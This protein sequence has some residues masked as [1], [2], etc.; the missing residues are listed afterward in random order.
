M[1]K[2]VHREWDR[3]IIE[4]YWHCPFRTDGVN[5]HKLAVINYAYFTAFVITSL[6]S[7]VKGLRESEEN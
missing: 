3:R 2:E 1:R 4:A 6:R 5:W 7:T